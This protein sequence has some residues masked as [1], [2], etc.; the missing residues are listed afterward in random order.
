M[1]TWI[2]FRPCMALP[3]DLVSTAWRQKKGQ[4]QTKSI[5]KRHMEPNVS[6][7]W[8][9][10]Y[11]PTHCKSCWEMKSL[12]HSGLTVSCCYMT[13]K[14][15]PHP[16]IIMLLESGYHTYSIS[17]VWSSLSHLSHDKTGQTAI[18]FSSVGRLDCH[19]MTSLCKE[20]YYRDSIRWND[21]SVWRMFQ[22]GWNDSMHLH[23][24]FVW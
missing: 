7:C 23:Q 24:L 3:F 20:V 10:L 19:V 15:G 2:S 6:H 1:I 9:G 8:F 16:W 14:K 21:S 11:R 12:L 18:T 22:L 17:R 5:P 4:Q 13:V